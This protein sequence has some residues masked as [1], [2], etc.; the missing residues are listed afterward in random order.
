MSAYNTP[1]DPMCEHCG[2]RVHATT[3][4]RFPPEERLFAFRKTEAETEAEKVEV[5]PVDLSLTPLQALRQLEKDVNPLDPELQAALTR[6]WH[7]A[8]TG[9]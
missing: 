1:E 3:A 7:L 4:C 8:L 2:S 9:E 5:G 6:L